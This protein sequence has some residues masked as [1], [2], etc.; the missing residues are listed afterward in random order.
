M[1][2]G[3][4]QAEARLL[5]LQTEDHASAAK[6]RLREKAT[7]P[8]AGGD[9]GQVGPRARPGINERCT[10]PSVAAQG[11]GGEVAA[12]QYDPWWRLPRSHLVPEAGGR[13]PR[14][15]SRAAPPCVPPRAR[16]RPAHARPPAR[17]NYRVPGLRAVHSC[18]GQAR[19]ARASPAEGFRP[20]LMF[21]RPGRPLGS[22]QPAPGRTRASRLAVG[23]QPRAQRSPCVRRSGPDGASSLGAPGGD[24]HSFHFRSP[25]SRPARPPAPEATGRRRGRPRRGAGAG[26][27]EPGPGPPRRAPGPGV[28]G[29]AATAEYSCP[30]W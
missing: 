23:A 15:T 22:A 27:P 5:V 6:D 4:S 1:D 28:G 26:G 24:A 30:Q 19:A 13:R 14:G 2:H 16:R 12:A 11:Y 7:K 8:R 21:P 20:S 25:M 3:A 17:A 9:S 29:G 18:P 10:G